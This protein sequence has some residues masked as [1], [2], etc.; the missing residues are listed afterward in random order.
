VDVD[1]DGP[2][3][4]LFVCTGNICRSPTAQALLRQHIEA[5]GAG[6]SLTVASAGVGT[7]SGWR[8]DRT[9]A[10]LLNERALPD[11]TDFRSRKL[12]DEIVG[13]ADLVLTGTRDHRLHIGKSWPD[14]Y[15]RTFSLRECAFLLEGMSFET[16]DAL[17]L[18][19]AAR[20]HAV[21]RWL[22]SERGLVSIPPDEL[23]IADPIG[24]RAKAYRRMVEE[25][26]AATNVLAGV[27]LPEVSAAAAP[28]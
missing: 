12:S 18:D 9:V 27:L 28:S 5:A 11:L 6:K 14:A 7:E 19:S 8:M 22:Q 1:T 10:S 13:E 23:D 21:L 16:R 26:E 17:G 3:R 4:I 25:V 15:S 2:F 20:G 24:R